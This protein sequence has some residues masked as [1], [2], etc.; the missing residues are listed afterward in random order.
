MRA[1]IENVRLFFNSSDIFLQTCNEAGGALDSGPEAFRSPIRYWI[2][3]LLFVSALLYLLYL[4]V[5]L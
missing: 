3:K 5:T 1:I 2:R 4:W